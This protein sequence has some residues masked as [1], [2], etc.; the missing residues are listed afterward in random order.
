MLHTGNKL[1]LFG[2]V[3]HKRKSYFFK[4]NSRSGQ[5]DEQSLT[6]GIA[7]LHFDIQVD[8]MKEALPGRQIA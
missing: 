8:F 1:D 7:L 3:H 6:D 2:D 4:I 5:C